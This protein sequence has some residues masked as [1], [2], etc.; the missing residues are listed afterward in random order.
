MADDE[1]IYEFEAEI[2]AG[3]GGGAFVEFPWDAREEFGKGRVP[4]SCTFDGVPYRGSLVKMGRPRHLLIIRKHIREQLG[5]QVGDEV[6]VVLREDTRPREVVVPAELARA[7][8]GKAKVRKA[9]AALSYSHRR[10]FVEWIS[11]AKKPETRARRAAKAVEMIA[12]G[13][14]R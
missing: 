13:K 3:S 6:F 11:G 10:E 2:L 1:Y 12:A 9:F 7:F 5:K 14:T 8:R 4:V